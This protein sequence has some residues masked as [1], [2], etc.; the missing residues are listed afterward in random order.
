MVYSG[1][2]VL[3]LLLSNPGTD[4]NVKDRQGNTPVMQL[5]ERHSPSLLIKR[6]SKLR[7]LLECDRVDLDV[8]NPHGRRP[9]D[10]AR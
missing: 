10:S 7:A 1:P 4:P 8:K 6:T 5:L 2:C 3:R 9:E